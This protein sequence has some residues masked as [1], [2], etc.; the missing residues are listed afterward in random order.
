MWWSLIE[1]TCVVGAKLSKKLGMTVR[2]FG[3]LSKTHG[4]V[5]IHTMSHNEIHKISRPKIV[6]Y[7]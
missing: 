5:W 1:K 3:T 6:E 2:H 7:I 4:N